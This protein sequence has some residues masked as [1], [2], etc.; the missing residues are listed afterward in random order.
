MKNLNVYDFDKTI[1]KKD[2]TIEFYK[3]CI[4]KYPKLIIYLPKQ[5]YGF[6]LYKLGKIDKTKFK[7][8]FFSFLYNI[9]EI[10]KDIIKFWE[11]EKN[12]INKWYLDRHKEDDIVISA[13]PEFLIK[14][15][16]SILG[17]NNVISSNIDKN[18]GKCTGKN[19]KG[20]EKV[21]RFKEIYKN[22][23]IDEFYSDSISD[24]PLAKI[25]KKSFFIKRGKIQKWDIS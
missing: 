22:Q 5:I 7:E 8:I 6:T 16:C 17:V 23:I 21:I 13:S 2:C 19:C 18:T 10:D 15:I 1:Y 11:K 25:S 24:L 3:Y 12:N 20:E 9:N 14:P 4:I